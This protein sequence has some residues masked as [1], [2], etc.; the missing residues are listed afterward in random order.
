MSIGRFV[1][2]FCASDSHLENH[3]RF[4]FMARGSFGYLPFG[5]LTDYCGVPCP[6]QCTSKWRQL[7]YFVVLKRLVLSCHDGGK[8][9][10]IYWI[11]RKK[12]YIPIRIDRRELIA[13]VSCRSPL[14][15]VIVRISFVCTKR[16]PPPP[17]S[18]T[19]PGCF[20]RRKTFVWCVNSGRRSFSKYRRPQKDVTHFLSIF[21]RAA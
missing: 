3:E 11:H 14:L 13:A 19:Y 7:C 21:R 4:W 15:D 18:S 8:N 2:T 10:M 17:P 16:T 1:I 12:K 6:Q 20:V 5:L 9:A